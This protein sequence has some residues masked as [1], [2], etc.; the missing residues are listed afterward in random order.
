MKTYFI[1]FVIFFLAFG[2]SNETMSYSI[3]T[4]ANYP[5]FTMGDKVAVIKKAKAS[6]LDFI[7][8]IADIAEFGKTYWVSRLVGMPGDT[9]EIKAGVL[10]VNGKSVDDKFPLAY[11]ALI[12]LKEYSRFRTEGIIIDNATRQLSND[13]F[14]A[15]VKREAEKQLPNRKYIAPKD[16]VDETISSKHGASYNADNFGPVVVPKDKYF[17]LGDN[18]HF[19]NDSRYIG[20]IEQANL[21]GKVSHD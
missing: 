9:I 19:A 5:M 21:V 15:T 6:R 11:N 7:C 4:Y 12:S 13:S 10:F 1:S 18:R 17:V 14:V 20:F 8:Y 2:C 16:L 3:P